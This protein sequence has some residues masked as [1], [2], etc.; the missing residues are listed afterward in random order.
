MSLG[1]T[2]VDLLWIEG[3]VERWLRFGKASNEEII[4]RR[5]RIV[6]FDPGAVFAFVRWASNDYGTVV[7][8]LDILQAGAPGEPI[9]TLPYVAPGGQSLLRVFGW[10]RVQQVLV[11][12]NAIERQAIDPCAVAPDHWRHLHNRLAARE[13]PRPYTRARHRAWLQRRSL[14]P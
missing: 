13:A 7:A 11:A 5:R 4:D 9:T 6:A 3:Q 2:R 8:R 1:Q 14:Q 10:P 12:I